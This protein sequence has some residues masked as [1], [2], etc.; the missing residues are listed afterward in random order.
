MRPHRPVGLI[1]GDGLRLNGVEKLQRRCRAGCF[2][3]GC[4][5]ARPGAERGRDAE[6]LFV[7]EDNGGPLGLSTVRTFRVD[8]LDGG[9][10][11]K[12]ARA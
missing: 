12:P 1:R 8:G 5:M 7:E 2:R 9:L 11:L 10:K 3:N 6:Q 4:R